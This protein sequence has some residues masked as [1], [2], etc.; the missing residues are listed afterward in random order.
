M[1]GNLLYATNLELHNMFVWSKRSSPSC[2][3]SSIQFPLTE[4][5]LI[6]L[7]YRK[8][9][10][11]WTFNGSY[12]QIYNYYCLAV[13]LHIHAEKNFIK[14]FGLGIWIHNLY[15][16]IFAENSYS[17]IC[18]SKNVSSLNFLFWPLLIIQLSQFVNATPPL[19]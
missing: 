1:K 7:F 9:C 8:I 16:C 13:H 17:T 18:F 3:I 2:V 14:L 15:L 19:K 4:S 10:P 6:A 11:F 12:Y 5:Y